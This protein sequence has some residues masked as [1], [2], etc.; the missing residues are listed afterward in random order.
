GSRGRV[1]RSR[2]TPRAPRRAPGGSRSG[3]MAHGSA[4]ASP[5]SQHRLQALLRRPLQAL[6]ET[7]V[8][9]GVRLVRHET[10]FEVETA[11]AEDL[12]Q[13]LE[14][15]L[16]DVALPAGELGAVLAAPAGELDLGEAGAKSS[17]ADEG[18]AR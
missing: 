17:L 1:L 9:P 5:R 4:S 7:R 16:N 13:R 10:R 14:A 3:R 11:R 12:L 2:R 8:A 6:L 18:A 15:R